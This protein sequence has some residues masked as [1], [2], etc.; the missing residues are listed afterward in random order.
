MTE[1]GDGIEPNNSMPTPVPITRRTFL[2]LCAL[3]THSLLVPRKIFAED[4]LPRY[5]SMDPSVDLT[6]FK[7][8]SSTGKKKLD[9]ALISE[10]RSILEVMPVNPGIRIIDDIEGPNAFAIDRTVIKGTR[11]TVLFGIKLI[12][13]ELFSNRGGYAVAG[14]AAHECAHIYQFFSHTGQQLM[15]GQRTAK[16][17]ELHADLLAGYYMQK[18]GTSPSDLKAFAKS[19][20]E[21]GDFSFNDPGHHGTPSQRVDAMQQGYAM[22]AEGMRFEEAAER[23]INYVR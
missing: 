7:A 18:D 19:L 4:E 22:A 14:I 6:R 17:M 16:A 9:Q 5:C 11:G 23:G 3:T 20:Y 15:Q 2:S 12:T 10:M 21:K 1:I 8:R 13:H